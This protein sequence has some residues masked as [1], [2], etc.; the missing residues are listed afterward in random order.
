LHHH[1]PSEDRG[2][3]ECRAHAAPAVSCARVWK[4]AHT[5]IQVQRRHSGIPCA[6][7]LRLM[8]CSPVSGL[9]SHRR[10]PRNVSRKT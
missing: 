7:V 5:S 4:K 3:R 10:S 6:M 2:R 1:C 8:T 9:D